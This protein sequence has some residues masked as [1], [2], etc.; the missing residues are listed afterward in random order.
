MHSCDRG[1]MLNWDD[2][3]LF[4]AISRF[5]T[6]SQA[7][8]HLNVQHSTVS[9]RL[10][11][12]EKSL[13]ITLVRRNKGKYELTRAGVQL[14]TTAINMEKEIIS[15]DGSFLNIDEPLSGP[16]KVSTVNSLATTVLL[17][18]FKNFSKAHPEIELHLMVSN[19]T[20]NLTNREADVAIRLS[21]SPPETLIGKQI[22]TL[23]SAPYGSHEYLEEYGQDKQQIEWLGVSCCDYH[24]DW[25]REENS[26][27]KHRFYSD[28]SLLTK[29]ALKQGL[30]VS[31][32]FCVEGDIDPDL[33]R[34][35]DPE[36]RH[37][38]GLW[39]LNH[40]DS[41]ENARVLAFRNFMIENI[42]H[43]QAAFSGS[44]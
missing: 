23:S 41:R 20:V 26:H 44:L 9:R 5:G 4:L 10:K 11:S 32:L 12:L 43:S 19:S 16:L 30:G 18:M 31:Y 7:A 3:K 8:K 28:D 42:K 38:L 27:K 22:A 36:P 2:L 1:R 37:D 21:N 6:L 24:R 35:R 40:P 17:P 14:Q 13:G 15:F 34:F 33:K 29:A 25:T 39:F